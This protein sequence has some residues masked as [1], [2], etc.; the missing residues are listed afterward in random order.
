MSKGVVVIVSPLVSLVEDQIERLRQL[1]IPAV[2]TTSNVTKDQIEKVYEGTFHLFT[3]FYDACFFP[4][5]DEF[6]LT[7]SLAMTLPEVPFKFLFVTP[8][9][10]VKSRI[11]WR[12]LTLN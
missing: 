4:V 6:L 7:Y 5:L 3:F 9:K 11:V 10:L 2:Q 1:G 8:E 12:I